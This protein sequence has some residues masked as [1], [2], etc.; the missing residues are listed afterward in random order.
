MCNTH[1]CM[2]VCIRGIGFFIRIRCDRFLLSQADKSVNL[3]IMPTL[4][5][6][7]LILSFEGWSVSGPWFNPLINSIN[8]PTDLLL[9]RGR[10]NCFYDKRPVRRPH[11]SRMLWP[12]GPMLSKPRVLRIVTRGLKEGDK[13]DKKFNFNQYF[14]GRLAVKIKWIN[15]AI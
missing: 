4:T 12:G 6:G 2:F 1:M 3:I 15:F 10:V 8:Q 9:E 11:H 13:I 7:K 14:L 5:I